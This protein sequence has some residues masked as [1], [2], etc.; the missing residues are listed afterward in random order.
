M[1]GLVY[2]RQ[3]LKYQVHHV[4]CGNAH[5]VSLLRPPRTST[6]LCSCKLWP[7]PGMYAL[8]S[9][10]FDKRTRA[11]LRNAELGFLGVIVPTRVQTPRF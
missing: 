9:I 2:V 1:N 10:L 7:I 11:Y 6:T 5:Q 8:I 4:R 3:H